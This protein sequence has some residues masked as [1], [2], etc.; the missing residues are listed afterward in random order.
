MAAEQPQ[1]AADK[2]AG[3]AVG[4]L[5]LL[6]VAPI[7][8]AVVVVGFAWQR[9]RWP[10]WSLLA[11]AVG[12]TALVA[13]TG[14]GPDYLAAYQA[15]WEALSTP[16]PWPSWSDFAAQ[17]AP[18]AAAAGLWLALPVV[19]V[20]RRR[21]EDAK[22]PASQRQHRPSLLARLRGAW[23]GWWLRR[24]PCTRASVLVAL[25]RRLPPVREEPE[26]VDQHQ[27]HDE[28]QDHARAA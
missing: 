14:T 3:W 2:L 1:D 20:H 10:I 24:H 25:A 13:A 9:S 27:D 18:V 16:A 8:L 6:V 7:L 23:G 5:L 17:M 22:R 4:G 15:A 28:E 19:A 12:A 26:R 21:E 11:A